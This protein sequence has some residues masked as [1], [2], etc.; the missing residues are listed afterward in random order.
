M[1]RRLFAECVGL[2][3]VFCVCPVGLADE[4]PPDMKSLSVNGYDMVYLER[5]AGIPVVLVHGTVS[6]YRWWTAQMEPFAAHAR[7]IAVSLRHSYPDHWNGEGEDASV[8]QH[9]NDLAEFIT[10]F[11]AGPVHIVGHSRGGDVVLLMASKHPELL[12]SAVLMDPAPMETLLPPTAEARAELNKRSEFV[13]TAVE[14]LQQ[15]DIDGGLERFIDGVVVPGAWQKMPEPQKQIIRDNAWSIKSLPTDAK[16][17][18]TCADVRDIKVP[19]L[20]VTGEKSPRPYGIMMEALAPCLNQF[21]QVTIPNAAHAMNRAN[22]QAFN[23]AVL[24]F[25]VRH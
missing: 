10:G 24:D 17:S 23:A 9:A 4:L 6:D 20:L 22:P 11:R 21:E 19:I 16:Q 18:L 8:H 5:G 2:A 13:R 7:A 3:L 25:L 14:R 12:R 15:G 1:L